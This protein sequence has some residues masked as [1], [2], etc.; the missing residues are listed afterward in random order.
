MSV[1][2]RLSKHLSYVSS[3]KVELTISDTRSVLPKML[4]KNKLDAME[5]NRQL[6]IDLLRV[7]LAVTFTE[8]ADGPATTVDNN[9]WLLNVLQNAVRSC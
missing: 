4:G 7:E 9:D 5:P 6:Q 3:A 2:L 1:I 8:T